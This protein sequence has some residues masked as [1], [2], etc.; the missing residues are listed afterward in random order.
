MFGFG[1]KKKLA[2]VVDKPGNLHLII[3]DKDKFSVTELSITGQLNGDDLAM[4]REM[5]G[6][7]MMGNKTKGNLVRLDL[8]NAEFVPGGGIYARTREGGE[9]VIEREN[10]VPERAFR[11]CI[12]LKVVVLP[13]NTIEIEAHAFERCTSLT[14]VT[15]NEDLQFI[16]E[17][18]FRKC[19]ELKSIT[20]YQNIKD[21]AKETF[22]E[23]EKISRMTIM[24]P[25]PPTVFMNTFYGVLNRELKLTVP[26]GAKQTY[27]KNP[28]WRKFL[29]VVEDGEDL[30]LG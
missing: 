27:R 22:A 23:D 30:T 16:G 19:V 5:A 11:K 15:F 26:A 2:V 20:L 18:A 9:C 7:T 21:I 29:N 28:S 24:T 10:V 25:K 1:K 6:Y 13:K 12:K 3:S 17:R 4:L 14:S 8:S